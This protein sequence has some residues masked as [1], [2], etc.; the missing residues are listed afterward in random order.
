MSFLHP[1]LIGALQATSAPASGPGGAAPPGPG[2]RLA[3]WSAD[4]AGGTMWEDEAC[5]IAA[6]LNSRVKGMK[7]AEGTIFTQADTPQSPIIVG[8]SQNALPGLYFTHARNDYLETVDAAFLGAVKASTALTVLFVWK[9]L[10][11]QTGLYFRNPANSS[12]VKITRS[13][14]NII[15]NAGR[16]GTAGTTAAY[17]STTAITIANAIVLSADAIGGGANANRLYVKTTANLATAATDATDGGVAWTVGTLGARKP[18]VGHDDFLTGY[19]YEMAIFDA[20]ANITQAGSL[21]T[22]ATSKWGLPP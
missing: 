9:V 19:L 1:G 18:N 17:N 15:T 6:G 5:T 22:Y 20:A 13:G 16:M 21:F 12:G 8:A 3:W 7:T 2:N 11:G 10:G 4:G 14:S